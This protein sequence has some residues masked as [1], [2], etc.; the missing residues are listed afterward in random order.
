LDGRNDI[1]FRGEL[2]C[3]PIHN[4]FHSGDALSG[5]VIH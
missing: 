1:I 2:L 4:T 5:F 3:S